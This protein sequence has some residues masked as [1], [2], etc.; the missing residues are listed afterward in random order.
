[1][2]ISL[3]LC[4][5]M[6]EN[7]PLKHYTTMKIG[8]PARYLATA[9]T[10][11]ELVT[12]VQQAGDTPILVLGQGSNVIVNDNGFNGL[13]ILNR[14]KGYEVYDQDPSS[15][16]IKIGA[17]EN[18]DSVVQ[19]TT[20]SGLSGI[21][22]LSA[23]PGCCGA[24]PVQNI[25]AYGQE[26]ADTLIE[27]EAF[28]TQTKQFVNFSNT[29]CDF[30][31]R[32][33]I[34]NDPKNK[35]RYIITSISLE[36]RKTIMEPPFYASLQ[37][38]LDKNQVTDYSPPSLRIAVI[39]IRMTKLPDPVVIP[40]TGSF[41]RNP[42]VENWL[43]DNLKRENPDLQVFPMGD[44]LSKISAGWLVENAGI[45]GL[46]MEGFKVFEKNALVIT[47]QGSGTYQ[48]LVK[49]RQ[50]ITDAV[51]DKFRI[52]LEQEPEEVGI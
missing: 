40:N 23:I 20:E 43:A 13:V 12:L 38:Y 35:G 41:F 27:L 39:A 11:E 37:Q 47:N 32:R 16:K 26:I 49:L 15:T 5:V 25:G 45:K 9:N 19:R 44:N 14:I 10:K 2:D 50:Y 17:G 34:F 36:L 24:A 8:G 6:Q 3:Y 48:G 1:M 51:R 52:E 22:C 29:D 30:T 31:Y 18:W 46:E 4:L 21:E 7:I 33:S 42:M 28:D